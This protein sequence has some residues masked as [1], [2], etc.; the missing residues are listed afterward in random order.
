MADF[1]RAESWFDPN[2]DPA[3]TGLSGHNPGSA[4]RRLVDA[5]G[6]GF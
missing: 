6:G 1:R 5:G 3:F 2:A 4:R